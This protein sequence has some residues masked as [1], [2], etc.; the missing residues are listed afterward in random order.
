MDVLVYRSEF[1][2]KE[3]SEKTLGGIVCLVSWIFLNGK[4]SD[5]VKI[6][7]NKHC[8]R[9]KNANILELENHFKVA[10]VIIWDRGDEQSILHHRDA[11]QEDGFADCCRDKSNP[12]RK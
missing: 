1:I 7:L 4:F 3:A 11:G 6:K 9:L 2:L 12:I 10:V 5:F 8:F